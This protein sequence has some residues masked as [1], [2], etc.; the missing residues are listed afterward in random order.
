MMRWATLASAVGWLSVGC[1]SDSGLPTRDGTV[2]K[3]QITTVDSTVQRD[4][5]TVLGDGAVADQ[6]TIADQSTADQGS[7]NDA[8]AVDG[9]STKRDG[10]PVDCKDGTQWVCKGNAQTGDRPPFFLVAPLACTM[11]CADPNLQPSITCATTGGCNCRVGTNAPTACQKP[12]QP[13][14]QGCDLCTWVLRS[15]CCQLP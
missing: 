9:G 8:T 14:P 1:S 6:S 10:S 12:P 2:G 15:G 13:L 7:P 11:S 5:N 4:G 3:D